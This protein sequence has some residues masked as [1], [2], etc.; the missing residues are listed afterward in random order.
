MSAVCSD[1]ARRIAIKDRVAIR[2]RPAINRICSDVA[3][4]VAIKGRAAIRGRI[5]INTRPRPEKVGALYLP[6]R[7]RLQQAE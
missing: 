5:A 7:L 4:R 2:G 6:T 1:V 3:C